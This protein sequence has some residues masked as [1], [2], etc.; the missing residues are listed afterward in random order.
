ML[1]R[2]FRNRKRAWQPAIPDG[3]RIYAI[4]DIHGRL[5]LFT[6]LV[7]AIERDNN[8][9]KPAE[10][11]IILLG[12][13][14][15]R[16]PNSARVLGSARAWGKTRNVRFLSGNHEEMFLLSFYKVT[17]LKS[18][19][20][21]GGM[22]TLSSYGIDAESM[23]EMPFEQAQ[24]TLLKAVP[25]EDREFMRN[26]ETMIRV[27][28]Y[29]FVHAGIRPKVALNEQAGHDCRWIREPF[30]SHEGDFGLVVVHGHTVTSDVEVRN[31][32]IGID[33]GGYMSGVLTAVCLEGAGRALIQTEIEPA[34][35]KITKRALETPGAAQ[36]LPGSL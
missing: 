29:L 8:A 18:F 31:N 12:D 28:D 22:E 10:T 26:F 3:Q 7:Q 2:I 11:T 5:D 13:L 30:L 14:V 27:G 24:Q 9:R 19:L 36:E 4:G 15:D 33:T 32:R 17:A 34:G 23:A 1:N 16:G 6:A 20:K 35:I 21:F 25:R